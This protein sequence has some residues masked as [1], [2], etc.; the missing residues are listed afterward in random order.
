M[1]KDTAINRSTRTALPARRGPPA[2][3]L[4]ELLVVIAIIALLA[5]LLLPSLTRAKDL[6]RRVT[7]LS[8]VRNMASAAHQYAAQ[9]EG[10]Y[11]FAQ[12]VPSDT[13]VYK[14]LAWDF[15]YRADGGVEPGLLWSRGENMRLQQCPSFEGEPNWPGDKYT[16]Y[17][18]NT[19][20]IGRGPGEV[21]VDP[22]G[23]EDVRAPAQCALFGDGQY[24][25][26]A[27]KFMRAPL[28]DL[29]A[30]WSC[31][32]R[33]AGTQGYRHLD[34]TNVAFCDGHAVAWPDRY[35]NIEPEH[36]RSE[37]AEGT[38]FLSPDNSLYDLR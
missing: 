16:G 20:Y 15:S 38:G 3:T 33:Y 22:A 26:G 21:I 5:G 14:H 7:C 24:A 30:D 35:T 28:R 34:T 23:V 2:F 1:S 13:S 37:I 29:T 27:S 12:Y 19:S 36:Q 6:A 11:P 25:A 9:F 17:N 31:S 10:S 32:Y 8:N 4:I 18:Y